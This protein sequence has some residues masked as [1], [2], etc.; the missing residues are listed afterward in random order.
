MRLRFEENLVVIPHLSPE[1]FYNL[2][3]VPL[4]LKWRGGGSKMHMHKG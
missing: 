2:T 1:T 3:P 4:S